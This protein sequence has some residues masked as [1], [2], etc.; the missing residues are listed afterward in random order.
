MI[1]ALLTALLFAASAVCGHR[2]AR[3]I[4]GVEAN[5][6]RITLATIFLTIWA[7]TFGAGF[8]GAPEWFLLSGLFGIGLGDS[9]YFQALPRLGSRRTVLLC[10]CLTAPFA[11]LIEW[12][13]LGSKLNLPEIFSIAVILAGVALALAPGDHQKISKRDWKIG[14]PACVLSAL[15]GALGAVI[16]RKGYAALHEMNLQLDAGTTGYQRVLGGILLPTTMLLVFKWRSAHEHGG[17][18][19]EKTLAVSREKWRLLWPWVVANALAS[20]LRF[21]LDDLSGYFSDVP[22]EKIIFAIWHN[23]LSLS[24]ILYL[25]KSPQ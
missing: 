15:G 16:I 10:Q 11:A 25:L 13:W 24:L 2:T 3:Q 6:W 4:G 14:I 17:I 22:Q 1:P 19:Q 7:W 5:F 21:R 8:A 9:A 23:R 20:T 12:L 18:F